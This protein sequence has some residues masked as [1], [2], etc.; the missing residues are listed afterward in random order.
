MRI[1]ITGGAGF[2]GSHI[3]DA[4]IKEQYQVTIIDNLSTG[5]KENINLKAKFYNIDLTN[6][7][8]TENIF[9]KH[10]PE[11]IYHLAA[12]I[13][14]RKSVEDPINDAKINIINTLNLLDLAV[15]YKIKH[16]IFSSTGGAIY[17]DVENSDIPTT[18]KPK[19]EP[20]PASPYG[21]A[22]LAIEKYLICYNK[23]HGLKFTALRYSNV[24]GPRQNPH[25]EA[26]VIAIFFDQ[27]LSNKTPIIFGGLQAR[28]FVYV[29]DI[30]N[31]N[32][33]ALQ[34]NKSRIYNVGTSKETD[35]ISLFNK[36]NKFFNNKFEATYKQKNQGEQM[37]S[38][39]SYKK[40]KR[41]LGWIPRTTLN[42]GLNKT[43]YWY[44]NKNPKPNHSTPQQT[45]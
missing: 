4:L 17:G 3:A 11:I 39:I 28:D 2:I 18:E 41:N 6:F 21:C 40:I 30:V 34:D 14:V 24:Y 44:Q 10:K 22:K 33:K 42:E 13:D 45:P 37:R 23:I 26:G 7:Q 35:I 38:C 16:F 9:N 1:L 20:T 31:A 25:G 32:T 8:E 27:M 36:I 29:E 5:K 12:Q 19:E 15:K 43:Y